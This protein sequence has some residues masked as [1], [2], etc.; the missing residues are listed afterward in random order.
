MLS[1]NPSRQ[2]LGHAEFGRDLV[3]AAATPGGAQTFPKA[4][5]LRIHFSGVRSMMASRSRS[6][7]RPFV[8]MP[9]TL[10]PLHLI[11]FQATKFLAPAVIR[12]RRSR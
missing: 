12:E 2:R 3:D 4:A 1:H 10:Q 8:A 11:A 9:R 6:F 7:S 5:S